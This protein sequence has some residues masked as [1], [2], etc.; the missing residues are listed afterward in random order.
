MVLA[1]SSYPSDFPQHM[2]L[3]HVPE[4]RQREP[5]VLYAPASLLFVPAA[6]SSQS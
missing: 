4:S 5:G 1:A 2:K 6:M 3:A